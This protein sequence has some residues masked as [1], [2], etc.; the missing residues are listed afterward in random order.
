MKFQ[1]GVLHFDDRPITEVNY[2]RLL[3]DL[4]N[5]SRTCE[6]QIV[7]GTF[8]NRSLMM[9]YRGKRIT[10][11]ERAEIQPF[12]LGPYAMTWDGRL[13]NREELGRRLGMGNVHTIP[14]PVLVLRGYAAFGDSVLES[15]VGEFALVLWCRRTQ[16]LKF[17][18]S[19]CGARTLYYALEHNTLTWSSS[20]AHLV[21]VTNVDLTVNDSY[22]IEYL[23]SQPPAG[24]SP[25]KNVGVIPPNRR[26]EFTRGRFLAP[27]E[28]WDPTR[29]ATLQH[30]SDEEYEE[31]LWAVLEEAVT[32]R[33][34]SNKPV[35]A[36]L[37]GGLDSSTI[38]LMA[39]HILRKQNRA[40]TDLQ[41]TSCVY[42]QSESCDETRF[43][44]AV[45]ESRQI[46]THVVHERDQQITLG[47][48]DAQ[49][50][51][52]PNPLDCFPG[53]YPA[54]A[55]QMKGFD[56]GVLLTG[57]GGDH[58][59]W[60]EADGASLVADHINEG[61]VLKAHS[62]CRSWS[63]AGAGSYYELL[64]RKALPLALESWFPGEFAYKKPTFPAWLH[65]TFRQ[66]IPPITPSFEKC[67]NWSSAPSQRAQVVFIEHMFRTVGSGFLQSYG[68][69][70]I[71][72][73]Y[74]HRPLVEFCL[75]TPVSQFLRNG[76]TRSL[77]RRAFRDLLP[78]KTAKRVSKGLLDEPITRALQRNCSII[79]DVGRW[80][81]CDREYVVPARIT[82]TLKSARLGNLDFIG[83]VIRLCSLERWL[84]SLSSARAGD[85]RVLDQSSLVAS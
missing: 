48:D 75:G 51:G 14:D 45:E 65:P 61:R 70:Y 16:T 22:A 12:R 24:T 8:K 67:A 73:P 71:S 80:Q 19:A 49:F 15:L 25:L 4:A 42:E 2:V 74:T 32:V 58:L 44:Q 29:F 60:S 63:V 36:E 17:A 21:R 68:G 52:L 79:S 64:L 50:S 47:L 37:S 54:I 77:M 30:R 26:L 72:H 28:L 38:V 41:T 7:G 6:P 9:F 66:K 59:F 13:D 31:N 62:A 27:R 69:I 11:E 53:R 55:Q 40:T 56:A 84:R 34:R 39:D 46:S 23:L 10:H 33:L 57:C 82:E 83:S 5:E 85:A 78:A 76:E 3:G 18:R 1:C 35:F 81:I 43:I 20:F